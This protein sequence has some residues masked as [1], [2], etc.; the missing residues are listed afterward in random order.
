MLFCVQVVQT[1]NNESNW[2]KKKKISTFYCKQAKDMWACQESKNLNKKNLIDKIHKEFK[3]N[4]NHNIVSNSWNGL[5][6]TK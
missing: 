2:R 1:S 5:I 4:V 3:L 6:S